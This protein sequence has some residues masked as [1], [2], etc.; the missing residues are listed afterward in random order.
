MWRSVRAHGD[1]KTSK[2][3]RSLALPA[4]AVAAL[5]E[6]QERQ[7]RARLRAGELWREQGLVFTTARKRSRFSGAGKSS[8]AGR[9]PRY[10][11]TAAHR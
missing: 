8:S 9:P 4:M 3:R 5:T 1:V 7:A 10:L 11:R 6:H 2:S